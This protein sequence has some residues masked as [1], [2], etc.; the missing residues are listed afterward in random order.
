MT[1]LGSVFC[2][3]SKHDVV[4]NISVLMYYD[5]DEIKMCTSM[6]LWADFLVYNTE[7]L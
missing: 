6:H 1:R 5:S 2:G 7:A 3:H 4:V